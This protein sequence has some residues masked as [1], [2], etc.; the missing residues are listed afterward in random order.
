MK[1]MSMN[2]KIALSIIPYLMVVVTVLGIYQVDAKLLPA[3]KDFTVN[4]AKTVNGRLEIEGTLLKVRDCDFLGLAVYGLV[5]GQPAVVLP[6]WSDQ[7]MQRGRGLGF[8]PWGPWTI[9]I[10]NPEEFQFIEITATHRC[11]GPW[12]QTA[13]YTQIDL[14]RLQGV[15]K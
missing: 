12:T 6:H 3:V 15:S 11:I 7:E 1:P 9:S 10:E 13:R 14:H 8:Q 5:Q 4:S 2:A